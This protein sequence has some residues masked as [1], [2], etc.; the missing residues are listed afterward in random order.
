MLMSR[1]EQL[2]SGGAEEVPPPTEVF[3]A[4][5]APPRSNR[6]ALPTRGET[7]S[8]SPRSW[9]TS[10]VIS[11]G[12]MWPQ[13]PATDDYQVSVAEVFSEFKKGLE[14]M[15]AAR[16]TWTRTTTS[17]SPTRRWVSSTTP[18][19]SSRSRVRAASA[20][21]AE[22]D[23]LTMIGLLQMM[24]GEAPSAIEVFKQAL[25]SEH[26]A[27]D[28]ARALRFELATAWESAGSPGKALF[29]LEAVHAEGSA[30]PARSPPTCNAS[31]RSP[32]PEEDPLPP[33]AAALKPASKSN[34]A[35]AT[36][37]Q[38]SSRPSGSR[39]GKVGYV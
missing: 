22:I 33:R 4:E 36:G 39:P 18:S 6:S 8:I 24:K 20:R 16:R 23:C 15:V 26:A 21:S 9:R 11:V 31:P 25:S 30:L 17:A 3:Q 27:P 19:A 1:L 2:E 12:R 37:A 28:T 5:A 34:A 13:F 32:T 10:W 35:T 7:R 38:S 29:H 14:K